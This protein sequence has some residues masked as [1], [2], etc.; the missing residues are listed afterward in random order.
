MLSDPIQDLVA[1]WM[2]WMQ[3][4]SEFNSPFNSSESKR[5]LAM[6]CEY[7]IRTR[8]IAMDDIDQAFDDKIGNRNPS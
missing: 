2:C 5:E 7:L 8:Y 1:S 4:N 3:A 6:E